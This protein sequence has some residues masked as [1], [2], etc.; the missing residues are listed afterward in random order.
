MPAA[1]DVSSTIMA[2]VV[3][4]VVAAFKVWMFIDAVRRK[5]DSHWFWLIPFV[6][7]GAVAYFFMVKIRD[8]DMQMLGRR[9]LE[10]FKR[11]PSA[12]ELADS[13]KRTPSHA[14]RIALAQGLFDA[15]HYDEAQ[16][17]FEQVLERDEDDCAGLYGYGLCRLE[18]GDNSEA[19]KTLT[20][21]M[22][23]QRNYR[24][25]AAWPELAEALWR[26]GEKEACLELLSDLVRTAPR[27]PHQL[28]Q[29]RYLRR[30]G[31][32]AEAATL[33]REALDED[34]HS[35]RH[36]RKQNRPWAR[37]ARKLLSELP[38]LRQRRRAA[39]RHSTI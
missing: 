35:P 27:L 28:L 7:F 8:R 25:W 31:R 11:P 15:E 1:V 5:A 19:I 29:A 12:E 36:V 6:P 34:R 14:N 21:L 26:S 17:H 4:L 2:R 39:A 13:F 33:L 18:Q 37:K 24:D 9:M 3:F 20:R 38:A 23:Q 22:E 30:A 16:A 32:E 10:G